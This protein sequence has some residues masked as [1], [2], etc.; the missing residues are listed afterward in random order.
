ML[1]PPRTVRC[2]KCAHDW[3]AVAIIEPEAV[4]GA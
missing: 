1:D 4:G 2:A 3:T